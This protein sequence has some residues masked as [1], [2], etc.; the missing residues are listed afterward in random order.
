MRAA[1]GAGNVDTI[2]DYSV[3]GDVIHID[4]AVFTGL[5]AGALAAGAFRAGA[6]VQF[7]SLDTGLAMTAG[8][9]FVI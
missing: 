9:F 5:A 4:N 7:A 2:G 8:E 1:L 3:A 6:A